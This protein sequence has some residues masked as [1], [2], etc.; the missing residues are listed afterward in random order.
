MIFLGFITSVI[1]ICQIFFEFTLIPNSKFTDF[2]RLSLININNAVDSIPFLLVPFIMSLSRIV[3]LR[4]FTFDQILVC[5]TIFFAILLTYS[6]WGVFCIFIMVILF[7]WHN[8]KSFATIVFV[9]TMSLVLLAPIVF[10][11]VSTAVKSNSQ[12]DRLLS[13]DNIYVRV[14]LWGLGLSAISNEPILGYGFGNSTDAMFTNESKFDLFELGLSNSVETFQ[15]QSVHQFYLDYLMS[16]G[17][18]FFFPLSFMFYLIIKESL[19]ISRT[20][21]LDLDVKAFYIAIYLST[22]G[23]FIFFLQNVGSEM[24]YLY[25]FLAFLN[26]NKNSSKFNYK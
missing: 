25:G 14:Y 10:N 11:L 20:K 18:F 17:I 7:L 24:F 16:L 13:S 3:Y 6:R 22:I 26:Y 21:Y 23:L 15:I 19:I 2:S 9:L 1:S 12:K 8:R 4:K 5:L